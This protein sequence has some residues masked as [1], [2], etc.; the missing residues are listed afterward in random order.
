MEEK[1]NIHEMKEVTREQKKKRDLGVKDTSLTR[2]LKESREED[3]GIGS[4]GE[5]HRET[6][7]TVK[8]LE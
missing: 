5:F 7:D 8:E 2:R 1:Y 4:G 3:R 6:A